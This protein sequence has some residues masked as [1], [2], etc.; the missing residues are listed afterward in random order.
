MKLASTLELGVRDTN[1]LLVAAGYT[2]QRLDVDLRSDEFRWL[3]KALE[4]TLHTPYPCHVGDPLGNVMMFNRPWLA[5]ATQLLAPAELA[6][7]LN[8]YRLFFSAENNFART[9]RRYSLGLLPDHCLNLEE[10][11][12]ASL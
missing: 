5:M 7:P 8:F 6:K 11:Q 9:V 12:L 10:N 4:V 2:P 1:N 3:R